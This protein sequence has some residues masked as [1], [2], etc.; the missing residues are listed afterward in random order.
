ME[1]VLAA[2]DNKNPSIKAE[3][4]LFLARAFSR[5]TITSLPKK[6]LKAFCAALLKVHN[7]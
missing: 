6:Q 3:T 1:D 4:A 2:L 7:H 5:L